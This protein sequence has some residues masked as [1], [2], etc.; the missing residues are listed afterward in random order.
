MTGLNQSLQVRTLILPKAGL[1]RSECED[2]IGTRSSVQRFCV[3]DGAT[4]AFDSRRW[5]RLLTKHWVLSNR[6]LLTREELRPWLS[7]LGER[8]RAHWAKKTLPWYAAEKA[9]AG[10]FAAFLGLGFFASGDSISWQAIAIGDS[11]LIHTRAE[12]MRSSFPISDPSHFGCHPILVPSNDARLDAVIDQVV[13]RDGRAR[14]GDV[15]LILTDA[16]A[17]W[18]LQALNTSPHLAHEFDAHLAAGNDHNLET[19]I[20]RCRNSGSLRNDDVAVIRIAIKNSVRRR[21][22]LR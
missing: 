13:I 5:A 20:R 12:R 10:A 15:F 3:A 6:S 11:C 21:S 7:A 14:V 18:Y 4:E 2:S 19:L 8:F 17:A 9:R 16:I 1:K 22:V